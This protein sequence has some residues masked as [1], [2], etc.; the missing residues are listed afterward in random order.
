M[1][2][3]VYDSKDNSLLDSVQITVIHT[4]K[5]RNRNYLT[6]SVGKISDDLV[7]FKKGDEVEAV[8]KFEEKR[9]CYNCSGFVV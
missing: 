9:L 7:S 5:T 4:I 1:I 2:C 8:V 3:T 6:D